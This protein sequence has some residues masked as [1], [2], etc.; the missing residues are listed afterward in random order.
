MDK[1]E[2]LFH[3]LCEALTNTMQD[4]DVP[5]E[6]IKMTVLLDDGLVMHITGSNFGTH[7]AYDAEL[8]T[9]DE[10]LDEHEAQAGY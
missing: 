10:L 6:L 2:A 9:L 3:D 8:T 4:N 5:P 1:A 7:I